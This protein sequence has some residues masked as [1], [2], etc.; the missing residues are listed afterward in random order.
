MLVLFFIFE[1]P[2]I[3]FFPIE[4]A[5][6]EELTYIVQYVL[7]AAILIFALD[8]LVSLNTAYYYQG[9]PTIIS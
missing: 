4:T 9:I 2:M 5:Y 3:I 6:N 1:I 7:L 8:I